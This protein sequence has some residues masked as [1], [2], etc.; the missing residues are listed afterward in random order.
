MSNKKISM[1]KLKR[2]IQMLNDG[3]SQNEIC[4]ETNSSKRTVSEYKKLAQGSKLNYQQ[5]LQ[6][7]DS[8]LEMLL[9]PPVVL[10]PPD[11][12]RVEL[13]KMMPEITRRLS[14]RYAT[15]QLVFEQYYCLE[16]PQGYGYTQFKKYVKDYRDAR[17]Y[18]YHNT[19][20]PGEEWQIDFAGDNLYLTDRM[21][22]EITPVVVLVCVMPYSELPFLMALPN[23]RTEWFFRGL[24]K[25]LEYLGALPSVA[26]SDNMKQWVAKSDRYSLTLSEACM[27]WATHYGID[28]TACRVRKPRDKGPVESAVNQLYRYIYARIQDEKFHA[29]DQVNDRLWVLLD[30]YNARPYKTSSRMAIFLEEEQPHM[31]D[32]PQKMHRF[33]YRKQVKLG[34]SY[35]VCIG[36]EHHMYSVPYQYVS[37]QVNVMWDTDMVEVY[38]GNRIICS[39]PRN[40]TAYGY[41]TKSEHMPE[42]H[43]AYERSRYQN[44]ASIIENATFIGPSVKWT[45][46][47]LLT[48]SQFPQ[49]AYGK[50]QGVLAMVK[51]YGCD[52]VENA[53]RLMKTETSTASLRVL[54]NILKNNR[55]MSGSSIEISIKNENVRGADAYA[56][57]NDGKENV[58]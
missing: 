36:S 13:E 2:I 56:C 42:A 14:R 52:R 37:Q 25:G 38:S 58:R 34:P 19:Y 44:A 45:V 46:E 24:N 16:C 3:I 4:R 41:S 50:C 28:I 53:C 9:Q 51:D 54:T 15:I 39:H 55:D 11:P 21:S 8:E 29:L 31:A 57:I 43:K 12:R 30:E 5:L 7:E 32:L 40:F 27:E 49:Q 26:K 47:Y 48:Q 23:S 35:H 1:M 6:K 20:L 22:G 33:R 10:P 18:S 17:S